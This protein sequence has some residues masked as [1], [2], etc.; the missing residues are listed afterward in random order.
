[1]PFFKGYKNERRGNALMCS[2]GHFIQI[3]RGL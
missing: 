1:M 3:L 2:F